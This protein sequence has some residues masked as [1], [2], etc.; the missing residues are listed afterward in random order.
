MNIET[1]F[2]NQTLKINYKFLN[3]IFCENQFLILGIQTKHIY[4]YIKVGR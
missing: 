2:D 1:Y 3:N 4:I